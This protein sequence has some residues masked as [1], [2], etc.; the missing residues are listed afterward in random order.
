M[1]CPTFNIYPTE[2]NKSYE[3][4]TLSDFEEGGRFYGLHIPQYEGVP[5]SIIEY[6]YGGCHYITPQVERNLK[7]HI[8]SLLNNLIVQCDCYACAKMI[9]R[10]DKISQLDS[11]GNE[12]DA[13][14]REIDEVD[15]QTPSY[16][17]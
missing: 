16:I 10:C 8:M 11:Q 13:Q 4:L 2:D 17:N 12:I 5:R 15:K 9:H 14:G 6:V 1:C 3:I 7:A